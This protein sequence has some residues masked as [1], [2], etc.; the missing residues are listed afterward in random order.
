MQKIA[1]LFFVTLLLL[2]CPQA[3]AQFNNRDDIQA[4]IKAEIAKLSPRT[5]RMAKPDLIADVAPGEIK[6]FSIYLE[7]ASR[8]TVIALCADQ[9]DQF[10]LSIHNGI[11]IMT[12]ESTSGRSVSILNFKPPLSDFYVGEL[13]A[14]ACAE[15]SCRMGLAV[16]QEV[17]DIP[18][19]TRIP[20]APLREPQAIAIRSTFNSFQNTDLIGGDLNKLPNVS[21]ENCA[22]A[23]ASGPDCSGYSFDKW[24]NWCFLKRTVTSLALDAQSQSAIKPGNPVS[25]RSGGPVII[26]HY[27][28]KA[29]PETA[30][31]AAAV[32]GPDECERRCGRTDSCMAFTYFKKVKK[33]GLSE[34]PGTYVPN[35]DADSG[36]K[37]QPR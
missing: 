13:T 3:S 2:V 27:R 35:S 12:G 22:A 32:G 5:F 30:S 7:A 24:N 21:L 8:Y 19:V 36:A 1:G 37:R 6:T 11:R 31:G 16:L 10:K 20:D 33:C 34:N 9:C 17:G 25:P 4:A 28:N 14:S 29:F 15:P 23:C 18:A 26:E